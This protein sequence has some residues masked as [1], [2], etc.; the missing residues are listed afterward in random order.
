MYIVGIMVAGL[1]VEPATQS[2]HVL[3]PEYL[4]F[5]QSM[6]SFAPLSAFPTPANRI[7]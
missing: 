2:V 1:V 7:H 6:G 3:A 5:R 4:Q